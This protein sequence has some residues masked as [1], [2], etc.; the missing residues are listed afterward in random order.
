MIP[1]FPGKTALAVL[2]ATLLIALAIAA[3]WGPRPSLLRS[4]DRMTG[5]PR[6]MLWAWERPENLLFLNPKRAGV[7]FLAQ[8]LYLRGGAFS[9]RPRLQPLRVSPGT[10]LVAVVHIE[11][12][13]PRS[14][15]TAGQRE[16]AA[17]AILELSRLPGVAGIQIDFDARR[18]ERGFYRE[19]LQDVRG[20][21]DASVSL[22]MTALA[23]WCMYDDWLGRLPTDETV[24]MLFRMGVDH[25]QVL[26]YLD[27]YKDFRSRRCRT[28]LGISLDEPLPDLPSGRRV[29]VFN[30]KSWTEADFKRVMAEIKR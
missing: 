4:P 9:V 21:L 20:R 18:S 28:S 30:P 19:L 22:G 27:R 26:Y 11:S 7:A 1:A 10:P 3:L 17:A 24:P 29:Y 14:A 8:T 2:S 13:W 12:D 23:S 5:I 6:V 16:Q 15:P 25:R